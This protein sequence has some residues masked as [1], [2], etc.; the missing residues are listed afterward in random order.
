MRIQE[1]SGGMLAAIRA[2]ESSR[3]T[4]LTPSGRGPPRL[5]EKEP[6]KKVI[7]VSLSEF[8]SHDESNMRQGELQQ[9]ATHFEAR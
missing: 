9:G 6:S 2:G 7:A 4:M 3:M 8:E 5:H 1:N